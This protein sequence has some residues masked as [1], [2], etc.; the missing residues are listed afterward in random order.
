MP[1]VS[2]TR[3]RIRS[4][5]YL[6]AFYIQ[7]Y[8]TGRQ[9]ATAEGALVVRLLRNKDKTFWTGTVWS[10]EAAMKAFVLA[11]PHGPVMRKLLD[12]CDEASMVHWTQDGD[13]FPSWQE[14]HRRLKAE[15]RPS[16]VRHPSSA[17]LSQTF[18]VPSGS[19]L[20]LK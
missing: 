20:R 13:E 3:L 9:A 14:A 11:P 17:Q 5:R 12:W 16:K 8:R 6:P 1:F 4:W 15:G 19:D 18:P 7:A 10:S 2:I